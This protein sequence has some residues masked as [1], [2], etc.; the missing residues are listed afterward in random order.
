MSIA[1][2]ACRKLVGKCSGTGCFN[3]YNNSTAAFEI[4][5]DNRQS[6]ASYFYCSG[7]K[8][9]LS[10]DEDWNH[11]IEQLKKR[12]V[13]IIHLALCIKVECDN[14]EKHEKMLEKEGFKIV[15][16]SH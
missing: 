8:E 4:Y 10:G 7:C 12:E 16:G 2:M 14:Y 3:A 13:D 5:G 1:I 15:H 6:L 9:T 11:K